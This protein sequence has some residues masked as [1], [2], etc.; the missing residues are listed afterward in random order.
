MTD[1]SDTSRDKPRDTSAPRMIDTPQDYR[2]AGYTPRMPAHDDAAVRESKSSSALP[3][4]PASEDVDGFKPL[5]TLPPYVVSFGGGKETG[6]AFVVPAGV[7]PRHW[8]VSMPLGG[9]GGKGAAGIRAKAW[10]VYAELLHAMHKEELAFERKIHPG[11]LKDA[12]ER[13]RESHE[14]AYRLPDEQDAV[15]EQL[16]LILDWAELNDEPPMAT[17]TQ[18]HAY[19][20]LMSRGETLEEQ[21]ELADLLSHLYDVGIQAG[22]TDINIMK[23]LT[24]PAA[25]GRTMKS[26]LDLAADFHIF[27]RPPALKPR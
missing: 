2:I 16:D 13:F 8:P 4:S 17:I 27:A 15:E 19:A 5:V 7:R 22:Y 12:A 21:A 26:H 24:L 23:G 1:T 10:A 20:F 25:E 3:P 11:T 6:Y 18:P 14:F 9:D